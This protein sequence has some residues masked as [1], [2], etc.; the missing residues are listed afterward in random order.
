MPSNTCM[1]QLV[2]FD[3]RVK[4]YEPD[5][6]DPRILAAAES[7]PFPDV[8]GDMVVEQQRGQQGYIG[9]DGCCGLKP[10]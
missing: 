7:F 6:P 2:P 8:G 4:C 10:E 9:T 5:V 1:F 3:Q